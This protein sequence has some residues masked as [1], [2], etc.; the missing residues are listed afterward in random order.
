MSP[1]LPSRATSAGP[2][3]GAISLCTKNSSGPSSLP[4]SDSAQNIF[5][6][7][8]HPSGTAVLAA[9]LS[10]SKSPHAAR[11]KSPATS[12]PAFFP[13]PFPLPQ[14]RAGAIE[15]RRAPAPPFPVA[16]AGV[17]IPPSCTVPAIL[18][19]QT[20]PACSVFALFPAASRWLRAS[21]ARQ[22]RLHGHRA[23]RAQRLHPPAERRRARSRL[24][25]RRSRCSF[26]CCVSRP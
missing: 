14:S 9:I 21:R 7:T 10:P 13:F 18:P 6:E 4:L 1:S 8:E 12:T 3:S 15:T 19:A 11:C 26:S 17:R 16:P 22:I 20:L 5:A 24:A 2:P 23:P 25:V